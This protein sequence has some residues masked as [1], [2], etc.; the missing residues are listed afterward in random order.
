MARRPL[1]NALAVLVAACLGVAAGAQDVTAPADAGAAPVSGAGGVPAVPTFSAGLNSPLGAPAAAPVLSAPAAAPAALATGP[2]VPAAAGPVAAHAAVLA[3]APAAAASA[4]P[5]AAP[6]AAA[7]PAAAAADETVAFRREFAHSNGAA[8]AAW[9]DAAQNSAF[10]GKLDG[11][12]LTALFDG[13]KVQAGAEEYD[14]PSTRVVKP[15]VP[16]L[17]RLSK[18]FAAAASGPE[19]AGPP[20]V[21]PPVPPRA[22]PVEVLSGKLGAKLSG[23]WQKVKQGFAAKPPPAEPAPMVTAERPLPLDRNDPLETPEG[24]LVHAPRALRFDALG[25]R[26]HFVAPD[27]A[28]SEPVADEPVRVRVERGA[29]DAGT[30]ALRARFD[31]FNGLIEANFAALELIAQSSSKMTVKTA[32]LVLAKVEEMSALYA[33]MV[34][35]E[36]AVETTSEVA[37]L[38]I[39]FDQTVK[40]LSDG[41]LLPPAAA[42]LVMP[43]ET[44]SLH[45]EINKLHQAAL[46]EVGSADVESPANLIVKLGSG[47]LER[48]V[49][50]VDLSEHP[51]VK[52]GR[53]VSPAFKALVEAM[54]R[55]SDQPKGSLLLQ[56]H[57]FWGHFKLGAHSAEVY[58]NFLPP[59]EGGMIRVRYQ[60]L[61]TG[62]DNQTRLYYVARLLQKAGFHVEQDNGFLTAVVDKDHA[63][64]SV[65]EMT[66]TFALVVQALHA[67]VGVDFAL[68]ILVQGA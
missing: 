27:G 17:S 13:E 46:R 62:Y 22:D 10:A 18:P 50:L 2:L 28:P 29:G 55:S 35:P 56:D 11:A 40:G 61:G 3:A 51:L 23:L 54:R 65:D 4:P 14:F 16:A 34:G 20:V 43:L 52:D 5:S 58:A 53:L 21:A 31:S 37:S 68:P 33:K 41:D 38:G 6:P 25:Y 8:A 7:A 15:A 67:T 57:Q 47:A 39:G 1:W 60:E 24:I 36:N 19:A 42:A 44:E 30:A 49:A 9:D 63:S 32:R 12:Q 66:D 45:Y 48:K 64:Q 59:D 26:V